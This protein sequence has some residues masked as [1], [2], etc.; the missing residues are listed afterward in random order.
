MI[1]VVGTGFEKK[2]WLER[3]MGSLGGGNHFVEVD[4]D[5]EGN[6]YLVIHTGSRNL[7][8][9]VAMLYQA[10]AIKSIH[11]VQDLASKQAELIARYKAQKARERDSAGTCGV[12]SHLPACSARHSERIVLSYRPE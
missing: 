4:E 10:M 12:K 3:S 8:K 9:Q 11:G 1:Y 7:G 6:K 5:E 2:D